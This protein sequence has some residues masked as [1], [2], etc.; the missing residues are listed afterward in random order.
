MKKECPSADMED[1][2]YVTLN[3]PLCMT[4]KQLQA[5]VKKHGGI[6]ANKTRLFLINELE[7]IILF[8]IRC[9][10]LYWRYFFSLR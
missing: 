3:F 6:T 7:S 9:D 10:S 2:E 5:E 4:K 1:E 8:Q